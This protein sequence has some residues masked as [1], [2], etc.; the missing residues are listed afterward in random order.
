MHICVHALVQAY[1]EVTKP[2]ECVVHTD[3]LVITRKLCCCFGCS[4]S[5]EYMTH[6]KLGPHGPF[7]CSIPTRPKLPVF[8][9]EMCISCHVV[10]STIILLIPQGHTLKII[11]FQHHF[12]KPIYHIFVYCFST[13]PG[14]SPVYSCHC[15]LL[16]GASCLE[17]PVADL[18]LERLA[19]SVF[20]S[21]AGRAFFGMFQHLSVFAA[22]CYLVY[23][24]SKRTVLASAGDW[25]KCLTNFCTC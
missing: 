24:T 12:P 13:R 7:V 1:V 10:N 19:S 3:L 11:N 14:R 21:F 18:L 2:L 4:P 6:S 15:H 16:R 25:P 22:E 23:L 20:R 8:P 9:A 5:A 17:T